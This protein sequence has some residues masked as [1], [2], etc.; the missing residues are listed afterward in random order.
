M[1]RKSNQLVGAQNFQCLTEYV[2][3]LKKNKEQL[4]VYSGR[5][6]RIELIRRAGLKP[7]VRQNVNV[8]KF[9]NQLDE[10]LALSLEEKSCSSDLYNREDK[11]ELKKYIDG[12]HQKIAMLQAELQAFK[13]GE[14]AEDFI[15]KT[16][17]LLQSAS[18]TSW[19]HELN[20]ERSKDGD[21]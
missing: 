21:Q 6:N 13:R 2:E 17:K 9:F 7:H 5:I 11:K 8:T 19:Q 14:F 18:T 4:P 1:I 10:E 15:T 16:S 20:M 12:L 3:K